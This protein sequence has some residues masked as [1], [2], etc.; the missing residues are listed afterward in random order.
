VRDR[1]PPNCDFFPKK[2]RK[3]SDQRVVSVQRHRFTAL[4][5]VP[6]ADV[7][8][9]GVALNIVVGLWDRKLIVGIAPSCACTALNLIDPVS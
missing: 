6:Q 8:H 5:L 3:R 7:S 4:P 9:D 2:K 1:D